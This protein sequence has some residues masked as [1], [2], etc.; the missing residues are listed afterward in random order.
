MSIGPV[1]PGFHGVF[2]GLFVIGGVY[3][4]QQ[5][6]DVTIVALSLLV[7]ILDEFRPVCF[8]VGRDCV[9]PIDFLYQVKV[10]IVLD[11]FNEVGIHSKFS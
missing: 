2:I 3:C 10:A 11:L 9:H 5:V 7:V 6:L 1:V 4:P 8:I